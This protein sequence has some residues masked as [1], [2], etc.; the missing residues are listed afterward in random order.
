MT[1][2]LPSKAAAE[3]VCQSYRLSFFNPNN[4]SEHGKAMATARSGNVIGGGDWNEARIIPDFSPGFR[5]R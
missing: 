4:Y 3:I 2:I 5:K 1:H